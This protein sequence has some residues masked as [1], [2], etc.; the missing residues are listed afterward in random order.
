[1]KN[2]RTFWLAFAF[3][4]GFLVVLA[5]RGRAQD[6]PGPVIVKET[7]HAFLPRLG[8]NAP[9]LP[10]TSRPYAEETPSVQ[11]A[12]SAAQLAAP[13]TQAASPA[14]SGSASTS[15]TTNSG[16]DILGLGNGFPGYSIQNIIP[17]TNGAAG[18][19]Q[20]VQFVNESIAVFNKSNGNLIS[21][22]TNV[23]TLWKSLGAPCSA[24]AN[25]DGIVQFDKMANVW[26]VMM[27]LYTTPPYFCIA[28][29]TSADA[30]G[31]WNL[32]AF[33]PPPNSTLCHCRMMPDYPKLGIWPD[34]YYISYHQA[35][36]LNYEGPAA[37]AVNRAAMLN[38]NAATM[39]CFYN[40]GAS[41]PAWLPSDLDGSTPPPSG[42]P[43]YYLA[44]DINDHSLDIWQFHVD[45]NTPSNST[46][47]GPTNIP[48]ASFL[49]PC[50]DGVPIF[51]PQD[52]CVPQSGTSQML[53]AFGDELMYRVA[54]RN[55]G[56]YQSL[57]ANHTVQVASG[58]NQTGLRWYELRNSGSGFSVYQQGTYSPDASYRWMGSIGMDKAGDIAM[59]Y[60]V[61]SGSMNPSIRYTGRVPGDALG[62]MEN[63]VDVLNSASV[64]HASQTNTY[65]W[66][67]YASLAID[68]SDDCTFWYTT[69][70]QPSGGNNHWSTRIA[71]FNFPTCSGVTTPPAW[72][73][74][75]KASIFGNPITSLTVPAT[76]SGNLLA[77][78]VMFNGNT[79]I[80]SI[81]DN[82]GNTYVSAGAR[83]TKSGNSSEIWYA[84]SSKSGA[85]V[86]TPHFAGSP[87]H[88]EIT[89]WEVS[90][91]ATSGPDAA[92]ATTGNITANNTA[93]ASVTTSQA[94][95]FVVSVMFAGSA[96]LTSMTSGNEF[97]DDFKT[98]GNGWARITSNSASAGAHQASWYTANPTGVY[99]SSSVAFL[100]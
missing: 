90:G 3:I 13:L 23:N 71:S 81:S 55:F 60:N 21:G 5:P 82:A 38:G 9:T 26:V 36:N 61:S 75:N 15:L 7:K 79:S 64:P 24:T 88:V 96:N 58:S 54:Y 85:T 10:K 63:E 6:Q 72:S 37:C 62:Q 39:Q 69:E 14:L 92:N 19:T 25:I 42:S 70:Y 22:P 41:N 45:W 2:A 93:G 29:S 83:A 53:G 32:Y 67:D 87:T 43:N 97:T 27:P 66:G 11:V 34:A 59:G 46:L 89:S 91:L 20:Y 44:Y 94:G 100:P 4:F 31:S 65:R 84:A 52:N 28:V 49:E 30:T 56:S 47:T 48:V 40:T 99:C 80:S 95:D 76:G 35:W 78:A 33:E 17:S 1:M 8:E 51:T 74:V 12:I 77:V 16:L 68:P 86:I 57:V 73:I 98:N 18:T 50:G